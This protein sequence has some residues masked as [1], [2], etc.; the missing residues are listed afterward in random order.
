MAALSTGRSGRGLP[1]QG[2]R[3]ATIAMTELVRSLKQIVSDLAESNTRWA[4]V[5]G[6]AVSA[7]VEPR[8]TRDVDVAIAVSNDQ[9]AE[10]CV[11]S[12]LRRGYTMESA[13][14]Q[15]ST[16]RL[17][18]VRLRP[19]MSGEFGAIVDLLFASSGIEP[20]IVDRARDL[21]ILPNLV[22]PIASVG[23]LIAM[24]LLSRDD[25]TRPN[26]AND[27]RALVLAASTDELD[28]AREAAALVRERGFH[29][30]RDLVK[31]LNEAVE[32][33]LGKS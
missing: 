29:R 15:T 22:A 25:A 19:A 21:E 8:M 14:E 2:R 11:V 17:A 5:G 32:L 12:L 20:E 31:L 4:L 10:T 24:K 13:I 16:Q 1:G 30:D 27:L 26:D 33:W 3:V 9:Q 28:I 7:H 23:D 6:L 18:T